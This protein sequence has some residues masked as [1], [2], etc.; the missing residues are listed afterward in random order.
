MTGLLIFLTLTIIGFGFVL[1][2]IHDA[3]SKIPMGG[4]DD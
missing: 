1:A 4:R 3:L 2:G